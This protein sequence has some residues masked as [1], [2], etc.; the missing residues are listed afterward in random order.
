MPARQILVLDKKDSPWPS[1]IK[2]CFEETSS[3]VHVF[4]NPA[5]A[6]TWLTQN[7]ADFCFVKPDLLSMS[8]AQKL[9]FLRETSKGFRLFGLDS[10]N[11]SLPFDDF[12][13]AESASMAAFQKKL[14]QH[15]E[16]ADKIKVMIVDDEKDIA[17]MIQ[18]FLHDRANPGFAVDYT[19]D[20]RKALEWMQQKNYDVAVLDVKMPIMDG[21]DIYRG[22]VEKK[23]STAVIVFFD[24]ISGDE[25][26]DIRKIGRP[27]I[28]DKGSSHSSMPE[29]LGLI[30]K[31]AYFG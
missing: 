15:L 10:K 24:A 18:D 12:V 26:S 6:S 1:L 2:E 19:D 17:R 28:V 4:D 3:K 29:M 11:K 21:R 22:I 13:D 23:I 7:R 14:T 30:K 5:Q 27:A 9:K 16:F 20:G 25:I 31:M 8:M